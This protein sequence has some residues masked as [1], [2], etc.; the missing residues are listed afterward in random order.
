MQ[1]QQNL[2]LITS[3]IFMVKT[4]IK[5]LVE[6]TSMMFKVTKKSKKICKQFDNEKMC[7]LDSTT[8]YRDII[9]C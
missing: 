5:Q 7:M 6:L 4:I 8:F 9:R 1:G 2:S 3:Q